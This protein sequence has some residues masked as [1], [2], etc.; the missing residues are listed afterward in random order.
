MGKLRPEK[1]RPGWV[2]RQVAPDQPPFPSFPRHLT[3]PEVESKER[4]FPEPCRQ[5]VGLRGGSSASA[6]I[7]DR[8]SFGPRHGGIWALRILR[9]VRDQGNKRHMAGKKSP[10]RVCE[11]LESGPCPLKGTPPASPS[12]CL[13]QILQTTDP[14]LISTLL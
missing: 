14:W 13:T 5:S 11:A 4:S 9:Q 10:E 8:P 6:P 1:G 7:P 3:D 12:S 2:T